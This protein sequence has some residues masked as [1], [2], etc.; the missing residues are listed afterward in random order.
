ME[1]CISGL[2]HNADV[3]KA[4]KLMADRLN[5]LKLYPYQ[6]EMINLLNEI[7]TQN[8]LQE[9]SELKTNPDG[10]SSDIS[11]LK[12][13]IKHCKNF[14]ERKALEKQLNAAYK[15]IKNRRW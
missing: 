10:F 13:R 4:L 14:L 9:L 11:S 12:K 7:N 8:S 3:G 2:S 1:E 5:E 15:V 6:Y